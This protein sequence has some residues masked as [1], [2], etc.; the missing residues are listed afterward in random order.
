MATTAA[1]QKKGARRQDKSP[2][3]HLQGALDE[4]TR[5]RDEAG[6]SI[7]AGIDTAIERTRDALKDAG[8]DARGQATEWQRT[9]EKATD[10]L[11]HELGIVAVRAQN[12]PEGLRAMSAEIRKRKAEL[13]PKP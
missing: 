9:L 7:R 1:P 3:D 2:T 4:L 10:E 5:A 8:S 12:S 13:T 6:D 11:R